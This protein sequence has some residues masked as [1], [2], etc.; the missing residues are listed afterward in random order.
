MRQEMF[1]MRLSVL[2]AVLGMICLGA[3]PAAAE[4]PS[5]PVRII[6]PSSPGGAADTFARLLADH[7]AEIFKERFYVENRAG[8]GGLIGSQAA[9]RAEPDGYTLVTSSVGYPVIAP[10]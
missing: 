2:T 9:A 8:A 4:W 3:A 7:L 10:A 1:A 5:R 6:A